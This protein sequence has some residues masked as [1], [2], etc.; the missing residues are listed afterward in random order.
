MA[1][2]ET[3]TM[4]IMTTEYS[5]EVFP[6][7]EAL[8]TISSGDDHPTGRQQFLRATIDAL[9]QWRAA[10]QDAEQRLQNAEHQLAVRLAELFRAEGKV[11]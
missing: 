2:A 6:R 7:G 1:T 9:I 5:R 3:V 10:R 8:E 11:V 4:G